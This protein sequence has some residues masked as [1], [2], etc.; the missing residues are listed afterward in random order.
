MRCLSLVSMTL[1]LPWSLGFFIPQAK[2]QEKSL[3]RRQR[4]SV[5]ANEVENTVERERIARV[6]AAQDKKRVNDKEAQADESSL[7]AQQATLYRRRV[8]RIV[9]D[10]ALIAVFGVSLAWRLSPLSVATSYT[11]GALFGAAY[12]VLLAR[13]VESVG[14]QSFEGVRSAGVSQARFALIGVLVLIAGKNRD[15]IDFLPLMLGF[16]TYQ[17]AI[18]V[19]AFRP[20]DRDFP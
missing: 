18:L 1:T 14:K 8:A 3:G 4:V 15:V 12:L 5:A 9:G 20:V 10:H 17:L 2:V 13:Y 7:A 11:V 19:Q 16:F 6:F